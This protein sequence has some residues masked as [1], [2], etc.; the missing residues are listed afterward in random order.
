MPATLTPPPAG[1]PLGDVARYYDLLRQQREAR[2]GAPRIEPPPALAA[3][4]FSRPLR[5]ERPAASVEPAPEVETAP[6]PVEEAYLPV[7]RAPEAA[8]APAALLSIR[9]EPGDTMW[10]LAARHLGSG[11][12]WK[13]I[14]A[15]NPAVSNPHFIRAGEALRLPAPAATLD[16]AQ[17]TAPAADGERVLIAPGDSLWKIAAK[18]YGSGAAWTCIARA[19]PQIADPDL[20]FAGQSLALPA[21]CS[22]AR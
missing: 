11:L 17:P 12:L 14:A 7:R 4:V 9:V 21:S 15:V 8:P 20:I 13:E 3:P 5:E 2:E 6:A 18:T 1:A 16:A 10:S 19:N 22:P